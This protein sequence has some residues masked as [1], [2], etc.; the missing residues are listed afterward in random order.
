MKR[1]VKVEIFLVCFMVFFWWNMALAGP[2]HE[3]L[4]SISP[5]IS[6]IR[7][8][9]KAGADVNEPYRGITGLSYPLH[10]AIISAS[11]DKLRLVKTLLDA[12]ARVDVRDDVGATPLHTAATTNAPEIIKLLIRH[13]ARVDA[14]DKNGDTPLHYAAGNSAYEAAKVLIENG[15]DVMKKNKKGNTPLHELDILG[16]DSNATKNTLL[17]AGLL[18]DKGA[19]PNAKGDLGR[20][21]LFTVM[22]STELYEL[23]VKRGARLDV[24]DRLGGTLL[25]KVTGGLYEKGIEGLVRWLVKKGIPVDVKD[26]DGNTPLMDAAENGKVKKART[27]LELGANPKEKNKKGETSLH[28][29]ALYA[30]MFPA[31]MDIIKILLEKG[32]DRSVRTSEG[33]LPLDYAYNQKVKELL[34][35]GIK[36]ENTK[37]AAQD[38]SG[39]IREVAKELSI[40]IDEK[41]RAYVKAF[42]EAREADD[43]GS[44]YS[45]SDL[46]SKIASMKKYERASYEFLDIFRNAQDVAGQLAKKKGLPREYRGELYKEIKKVLDAKDA[47]KAEPRLSLDIELARSL[48]KQY[49]VLKDTWGK[50]SLDRR[51]RRI[52]FK[53]ADIQERVISAFQQ[54]DR[55]KKRLQ[56]F[57]QR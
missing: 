10:M 4:E 21:P 8:L 42:K 2:L 49:Q 39:L 45:I 47:S 17:L 20:T 5:D 7:G 14:T 43:L 11:D 52:N 50:W 24:R 51:Q 57:L 44:V 40:M 32:A 12:G 16:D 3:E 9:I 55:A 56:Q 33:K 31:K 6:K 54:A 26:K 23:L 1:I 34:S 27:L 35:R 28:K 46:N 36:K 13:G 30:S 22:E 53:S 37:E 18:I 29:A 41:G 48:K 38:L 15:A 19:D 25:H